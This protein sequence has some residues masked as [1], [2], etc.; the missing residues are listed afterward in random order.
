MNTDREPTIQEL[1]DLSG[2]I[3]GIDR[4]MLQPVVLFQALSFDISGHV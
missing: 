2:K 3:V 1:F 4:H